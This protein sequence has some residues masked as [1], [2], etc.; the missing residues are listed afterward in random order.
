[1]ARKRSNIGQILVE[2][3]T[4]GQVTDLLTVILSSIDLNLYLEKFE[5]V[6][7]D[8]AA[9]VKRILA[10]GSDSVRKGKAKPP[11]SLKRIMEQWEL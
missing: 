2:S 1:M 6:D 4:R 9:V 11:V 5:A 3:L 10:P 7:S 8:M